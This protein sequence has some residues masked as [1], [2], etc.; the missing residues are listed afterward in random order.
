VAIRANFDAQH[1]T[2]NGGASLKSMTAS[3]M[4]GDGVIVG[5]NSWLHDSPF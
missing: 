3:A 1:V 2:F 4:H 5:M